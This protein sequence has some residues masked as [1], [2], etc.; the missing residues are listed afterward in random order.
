M[1]T[2]ASTTFSGPPAKHHGV[3]AR[4]GALG[5]KARCGRVVEAGQLPALLGDRRGDDGIDDLFCAASIASTQN[6]ME[7]SPP[8]LLGL[9][10]AEPSM[11]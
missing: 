10:M 11:E 3:S 8:I 1:C 9:R 6:R 2:V 5:E 4:V 7:A